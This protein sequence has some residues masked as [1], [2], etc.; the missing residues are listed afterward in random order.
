ME[1]LDAPGRPPI[2]PSSSARLENLSWLPVA[3]LCAEFAASLEFAK[4]KPL[5]FQHRVEPESRPL[6][7]KPGCLDQ[8]RF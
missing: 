1:T 4:F 2:G 5:L 8:A 7:I 3:G 6:A